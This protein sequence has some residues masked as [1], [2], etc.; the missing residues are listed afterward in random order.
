MVCRRC[1]FLMQLMAL[2]KLSNICVYERWYKI[3]YGFPHYFCLLQRWTGTWSSGESHGT[4]QALLISPCDGCA[5]CLC[6]WFV[7]IHHSLR[8]HLTSPGYCPSVWFSKRAVARSLNFSF[9][10]K[11][12]APSSPRTVSNSQK[13]RNQ[14]VNDKQ[15]LLD[16]I[17][18]LLESQLTIGPI[19]V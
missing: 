7:S 4:Y 12:E 14:P 5:D 11:C 1:W 9:L 2:Y 17:S 18:G 6:L 15:S 19:I 16:S 8:D 13:P 3:E 10:L